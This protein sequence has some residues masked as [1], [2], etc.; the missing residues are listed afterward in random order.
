MTS[1]W[2]LSDAA[3]SFRGG[4]KDWFAVQEGYLTQLSVLAKSLG[5]VPIVCAGDVFDRWNPSPALINWAMDHVPFSH[6]VPGQH[7]LRHHCYEDL[8]LTAYWT[9]V[10]AGRL[11]HVKPGQPT[12]AG[13]EDRGLLLHAFPWGFDL[14]PCASPPHTFGLNL[15]VCH[16]YVWVKGRSFPGAAAED[17]LAALR[18][19][20]RGYDA[21]VFGDNHHGF[22]SVRPGECSVAN[23]GTLLRRNS[24]FADYSPFA[25][26]LYEDGRVEKH[27][28]DTSRDVLS[29]YKQQA[30]AAE[31]AS[32]A[33]F[34]EGLCGLRHGLA[35]FAGALRSY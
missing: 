12:P 11:A 9:L 7:D 29:T 22:V 24:D 30:Q 15:A 28:L 17:K 33:E 34:L 13:L 25:A 35:D 14:R 6:A 4:E 18:P 2:H 19:L 26:V 31:S 32:L 3:P 5:G 21:A 10:K 1:D 27:H 8:H 20:L 23:T 16:R